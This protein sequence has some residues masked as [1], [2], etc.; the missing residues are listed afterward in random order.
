MQ[1]HDISSPADIKKLNIDE[2]EDLANQIRDFLI[3]SISKTG[4]HLSSNLGIVELTIAMHYVFDSPND[5]F[6]FDVGHQSY[7]HKLLTGRMHGFANLRKYKG[8]SGFQKRNE[9]EHD[10]WEAGHSSTSLSAALGLC[11]ARDLKKENYHV[12]PVIGDGALTGGMALEAL[13][14]IGE[15]QPN[16]II[17]FNDND[18][19]ISANVGGMNKSFSRLRTSVKYNSFKDD[20]KTS[21]S[22][23]NLG[24]NV[25]KVMSDVKN[26]IRDNVVDQSIFKHFNI[27]YLGVVDGHNISKLI[28]VL[29]I[30]KKRKGPQIIHVMTDKG[31][32]YCYAQEDQLGAWHGVGAFDI[33]TGR[34]LS[35]MPKS[36]KSYS[37]VISDSSSD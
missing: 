9:S 1:L 12:V 30:A 33:E 36:H 37:E 4:G 28:D 31:K 5:K 20:L 7:V 11:I 22:K 15:L 16:M 18:M 19:S 35:M 24:K 17:I 14:H 8:I 10:P 34:S 2:L 21:L 27:D 29:K 32:G 3:R 23:N 6:I 26:S 25:L 13:N